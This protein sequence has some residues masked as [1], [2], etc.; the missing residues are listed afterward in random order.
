MLEKGVEECGSILSKVC[1]KHEIVTCRIVERRVLAVCVHIKSTIGFED[2][3]DVIECTKSVESLVGIGEK[4]GRVPG[5]GKVE[6]DSN[7]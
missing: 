4:M 7:Q 6:T 1:P 3:S 2:R 5:V